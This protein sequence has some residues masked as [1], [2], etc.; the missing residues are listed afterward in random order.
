[1]EKK[2]IV[3]TWASPGTPLP[4]EKEVLDVPDVEFVL[5][6]RCG[7][8]SEVLE[9]VRD[10]D[11]ALC[12]AEPYTHQV[13]AGAPRLKV[14]V[15][16]GI[17]LD[18]IDLDAATD[19]GVIIANFPGFCVEEVANHA[20]MLIL[21]CAKKLCQLDLAL[22]ER[23]WGATKALLSSIGTIHSET[24]GLLAFGNI[25]R[26]VAQRAQVMKMQVVAYDPYVDS[27]IFAQ[28][29]VEPVSLDELAERSDYVSCHLPLTPQTRGMIGSE[30]FNRMKETAHFINTGRGAVVVESDLVTALRE[31]RIAGA[32]LDV[33]ASEPIDPT[34][35]LCS[36]DNV[37]LTPHS[38]G[39]ADTTFA[40]LCRR[41]ARAALAVVRGGLPEFVANPAVLR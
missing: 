22:R 17:G 7:T 20:L 23:G 9:A 5:R 26:A 28:A 19:H 21:A 14:V 8:V 37:F 31:R 41:V 29:G 3:H 18:T 1:M 38:A 27:A 12:G 32:G 2:L 13:F 10:A 24:L 35:P 6:G 30:F 39:Y 11:G 16:Y 40:S 36:M 4:E 15:R 25:A 34:H 33:Y